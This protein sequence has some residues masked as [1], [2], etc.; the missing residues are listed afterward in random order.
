MAG[1]GTTSSQQVTLLRNGGARTQRPKLLDRLVRRTDYRQV[2]SEDGRRKCR[3]HSPGEPGTSAIPPREPLPTTPPPEPVIAQ[4]SRL[5]KSGNPAGAGRA[6]SHTGATTKRKSPR[7]SRRLIFRSLHPAP[8]SQEPDHENRDERDSQDPDHPENH[9][10]GGV[11]RFR[12]V[13]D[14]L[15]VVQLSHGA[16]R[17][18]NAAPRR[19]RYSYSNFGPSF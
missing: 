4:K 10:T 19:G 2:R 14:F 11:I 7:S 9:L 17:C 1:W 18:Q 13:I 3:R 12:I 15:G 5:S 6:R 8:W 16:V